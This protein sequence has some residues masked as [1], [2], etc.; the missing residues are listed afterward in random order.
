MN[1]VVSKYPKVIQ[2][3]KFLAGLYYYRKRIYIFYRVMLKIFLLRRN[4]V[5]KRLLAFV[6]FIMIFSAIWAA[7][8]DMNEEIPTSSI[9]E[10]ISAEAFIEDYPEINA[11]SA[12]VMDF[13]SGRVLFEKNGYV[14][15]PMASTTKIM[16]AIIALENGNLDDIVTVSKKAASI[17]G[18]TINLS[19][20]EEVSLR[21]LM[22]GLLLC[23]GNDAAIAISEYIAGS[24]DEFLK[25]MNQKAEDIGAKDTHFT[26]PHGLDETGHYSTAYDLAVITRYALNNPV[27]N[28]IIKTKSIT[29]GK[30]YMA[31]T[32]EM[33]AGYEGAD[34]VKTGYTGKAG[35]CLVT[36]AFRN[37][38]RFI[39]VV[40]FCDSRHQRALSSKKILDY[41]FRNYH[42]KT[43]IRSE[44]IGTL[45]VY[46]GFEKT[47]PIYI[48][49]SI[50]MPLTESEYQ[51][52]YTRISLPSILM[53]PIIERDFV[54]TMSVYLNDEI[55]CESVIRA[56]KSIKK[57]NMLE[58]LVDVFIAW[59]KLMREQ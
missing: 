28:E 45:P 33:L 58:Y 52:L 32:N 23:S 42:N 25:M 16:T 39:S 47:V 24:V 43:L 34:G 5:L 37:G 11:R 27:F 48:E 53:A 51:N 41:T 20:G 3:P 8:D 14:K 40:L 6:L 59:L 31:N 2:K 21:E 36:S 49:K 44:Y 4:T 38:K 46:K 12:L 13:E 7:A 50:V 26:S 22:Y 19:A 15:R 30:R 18:S 35:R 1:L 10:G 56:G 55:L 57:K 29:I 54:G 17:W 9:F